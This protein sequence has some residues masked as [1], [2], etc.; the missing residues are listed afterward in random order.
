[1]TVTV[2]CQVVLGCET[3]RHER[4]I[5]AHHASV[6]ARQKFLKEKKGFKSNN[7]CTIDVG[8]DILAYIDRSVTNHKISYRLSKRSLDCFLHSNVC[9]NSQFVY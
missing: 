8:L 9:V 4:E 5:A 2:F 1:M 3:R 7:Y 6:R